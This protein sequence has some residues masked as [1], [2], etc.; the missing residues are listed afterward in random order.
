MNKEKKRSRIK[1][2]NKD[3][4]K[5]QKRNNKNKPT[6]KYKRSKLDWVQ[7]LEDENEI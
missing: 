4:I 3:T 7:R 2:S 1:N 5:Q 6:L